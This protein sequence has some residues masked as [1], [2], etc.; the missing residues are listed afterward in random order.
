[1]ISKMKTLG[2]AILLV[3]TNTNLVQAQDAPMWKVDK[4]HTFVNFSI[5]HFFS[6]VNGKFTDFD[7]KFYLDF[8]N[9]KESKADFTIAVKSINT[10]NSKRDAHLQTVDFFDANTYPTM[11]FK[12][13]KMEKK[14]DKQIIVYGKLTIR[15]KTH[16]IILPVDI[17]GQ[18]EHPM[19]KG[20]LILGL[21]TN[22]KI[23][24]NDYGVGTGDWVA[25]MVVGN[26]VNI[27]I[28]MELNR[29]K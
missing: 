19:M 11:T 28:N 3:L 8:N 1:M 7:G 4:S 16:N 24:R 20:T 27:S 17:K 21:A 6:A 18:M 9:L 15:D 22:L 14:S 23:N 12:S 5:N 10:D 13:T 25:T 29:K 26:E 2:F